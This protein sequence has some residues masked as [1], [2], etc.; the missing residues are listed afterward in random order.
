[1][2]EHIIG[3]ELQLPY[4]PVKTDGKNLYY[5]SLLTND[6][7]GVV[8]EMSTS[9]AYVFQSFVTANTKVSDTIK[10]I[11][12]VEMRHLG[13]IGELINAYGGN[14]RYAV[15]S[16]SKC[17][18][19]NAQYIGYETNPKLYLKEN[20]V[21]EKASIANYNIRINQIS[22]R[23]VHDLLARII[24]DEENHVNIL[25]GLLEEFY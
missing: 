19:W 4:P 3:C 25:N 2:N 17:N 13:L 23:S 24:L 10:C 22:D 1:M 8:S 11:A 6:F 15:Q 18:F 21:N 12:L 9:L 14:P 16:G 7:G 5:A 20:I